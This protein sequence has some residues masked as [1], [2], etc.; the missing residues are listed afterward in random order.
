MMIGLTAEGF[1]CRDDV[2]L[3]LKLSWENS[4]VQ[5]VPFNASFDRVI[6]SLVLSWE[7]TLYPVYG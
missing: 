4:T 1:T 7:L 5:C 6:F 3:N 2:M